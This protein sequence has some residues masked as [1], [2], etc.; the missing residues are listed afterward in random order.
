MST[1]PINPSPTDACSAEVVAFLQRYESK[2]LPEPLV[3]AYVG[4]LKRLVAAVPPLSSNDAQQTMSSV[5]R[6]IADVNPEPTRPLIELLCEAELMAWSNRRKWAGDN[7]GT[8]ANNVGRIRRLIRLC[9]GLPAYMPKSSGRPMQ[10]APLADAMVATIAGA[11][12]G[13]LA[14]SRGLLAA[15]GCG[16][17]GKHAQGMTITATPHG[18]ALVC[19]G[20]VSRIVPQLEAVAACVVGQTVQ[21][22]DWQAAR[23][24]VRRAGVA[25]EMNQVRQT[26]RRLA[27]S[28]NEPL[29]M[30]IGSFHL[31]YDAIDA[32][33]PYA[34]QCL[35][36]QHDS[37]HLG[38]LRG[39]DVPF[40]TSPALCE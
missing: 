39:G 16:L 31:G 18:H 6:F 15:L 22:G 21:D 28:L 29:A 38:V 30:I 34:D 37:D 27:F 2:L 33:L 19:A 20:R 32:I 25:L 36:P 4:D 40:Q 5:C 26:Y 11:V 24:A 8:V 10:P 17:I 13:D 23:W 14:A 9:D 7:R 12:M 3:L 35:V 1:K